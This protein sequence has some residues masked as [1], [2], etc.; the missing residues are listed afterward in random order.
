MCRVHEILGESEKV[1]YNKRVAETLAR[2]GH[3]V[4]VVL[5]QTIE[6]TDKDVAFASDIRVVPVNASTGVTKDDMEGFQRLSVFGD[7]QMWDPAARQHWQLFMNSLIEGCRMTVQNKQFMNWLAEEK[8]DIAFSHMYNTCPIAL[9]HAAKIPTWIWLLRLHP[10]VPADRLIFMS[11]L[12]DLDII[13]ML[14]NRSKRN[15]VPRKPA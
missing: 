3:D 9:I 14:E 8:F 2:A 12:L 11:V 10:R 5:I 7:L 1:G 13:S 15:I 6:G 4:T